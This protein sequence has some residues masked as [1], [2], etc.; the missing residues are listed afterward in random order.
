MGPKSEKKFLKKKVEEALIPWFLWKIWKNMN[1]FAFKGKD[2]DA[3]ATVYKA[4]EDKTKWKSREE[5]KSAEIKK[6]TI[7]KIVKRWKQPPPTGIKCNTDGAWKNDTGEGDIGWV[8][9]D[10]QTNMLW[11]GARKLSSM[12]STL[13]TKA[14]A[15]R[16][17][18]QTISG[19][20]YSRVV[21]ETD[22]RALKRLIKRKEPMWPKMRSL[23]HEI[24]ILMGENRGYE[25][26]HYSRS[27][28]KIAYR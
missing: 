5:V 9:R 19:F 21:L 20:E 1:E 18:I 8:T 6:T 15:T 26:V 12:E 2:Y 17:A 24:S 3:P 25:V 23:M 4:K 7:E 27:G 22:S 28:N 11:A 14:K 16:W 10:H 13:E